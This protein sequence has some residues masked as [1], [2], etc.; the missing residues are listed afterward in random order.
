MQ[1]TEC[2]P[3]GSHK[4]HLLLVL[5]LL[6]LVLLV[7]VP[8]HGTFF[9]R[10][11]TRHAWRSSPCPEWQGRPCQGPRAGAAA[12]HAVVAAASSHCKRILL[13]VLVRLVPSWPLWAPW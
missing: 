6:Q 3:T 4:A 12:K 8:C 13:L 1:G 9:W 7:L 10:A 5:L 2:W 11:S